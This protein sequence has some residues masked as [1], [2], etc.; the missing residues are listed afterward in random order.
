MSLYRAETRRLA[1]RRF[2]RWLLV[3]GLLVLAAVAIGTGL[4]NKK[5]GPNEIAEAKVAAEASYQETLR[6]VEQDRQRCEANPAD[7][8]GDCSQL[9]TPTRE[10]FPYQAFMRSTFEFRDNF[11]NMV[12]TLAAILGLAAFVVGASYV[13]AEWTSGGM[14]NL[15]LWR[16]QR[17][18]VLSTK[19]AAFLVALGGLAV[20]VAAVW[21]GVFVLIANLRGSMAGMTAGAWQ[22][23]LL[24]EV[25]A[26]GL[27]MVAG[28]I[29]FGLA[30]LGRHTA[31]ALGAAVGAIVVFQFGLV[32]VLGLARAPF[33]EAWLLPTWIAVW[34][35]KSITLQNYGVCEFSPTQGCR[36][37]EL[38]LTWP[39][40]GGLMACALLLVLGAAM[41][42][43]RSRDIP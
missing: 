19:L 31:L 17:L 22:S 2:T 30:A 35:N 36:P 34:M 13:G 12:I 3:G 38:T 11:G 37:D 40:A 33:P 24:T 8:G 14:M 23:V 41:W 18:T 1:K 15:L 43:T 6:F 42:T 25:R 16:P 5:V 7:Y 28:A 4:S 32:A 9:I 39:M 21:T 29:G 10:D 26:V 20:L 27:I